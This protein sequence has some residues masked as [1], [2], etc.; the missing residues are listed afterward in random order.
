MLCFKWQESMLEIAM[1]QRIQ[2]YLLSFPGFTIGIIMNVFIGK[3][4]A[5]AL[6]AAS[7]IVYWDSYF[8][9]NRNLDVSRFKKA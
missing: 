7:K 6:S 9:T 3:I 2:D 8:W 4:L 1:Q 5:P